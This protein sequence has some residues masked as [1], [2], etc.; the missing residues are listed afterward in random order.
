MGGGDLPFSSRMRMV[1]VVTVGLLLAFAAPAQAY[2]FGKTWGYAV[3]ADNPF[4]D[5]GTGALL[6]ATQ[7]YPRGRIKDLDTSDCCG[8]RLKMT[9]LGSAGQTL[10]AYDERDPNEGT[11]RNIDRRVDTT[12]NAITAVQ[13]DF[14]RTDGKC[15]THTITRPAAPLPPGVTP[16][17][18]PVPTPT[19]P[20]SPLVDADSDGYPETTDCADLNNT[21]HPGAR[22]IAG[23]G[24]DDDCS[25]G[26]QPAKM[27]GVVAVSWSVTKGSLPKLGYMRVRDAFGGARVTVRCSGPRCP[28]KSRVR[29]ADSDGNVSLTKL[30]RKRLR[31]GVRLDVLITAPDTIGRVMRYRITRGKLPRGRALCVP[32]GATKPQKRC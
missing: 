1:L 3:I 8:I 29:R 25:G 21:V 7:V 15:E 5:P 28:F 22:E 26:D 11:Y 17:P 4:N 13:Y 31:S 24:I 30:F 20:P 2:D 14:C 23:N 10:T 19:P 18:T 6:P 27:T 12:P 16:T 9:V 32:V